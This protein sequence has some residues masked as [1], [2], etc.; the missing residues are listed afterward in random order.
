M[1]LVFYVNTADEKILNKKNYLSQAFT[2][3]NIVWKEDTSILEPTFTFHKFRQEGIQTWKDFNYVKLNWGASDD[4][5]NNVMRDRYYFV[6]DIILKEGGILEVQCYED[7]RYTWWKYIK[8]QYLLIARN[9]FIYNKIMPDS[10][11]P[12]PLT[13]VTKTKSIGVVGDGGDG[14]ILLTVSGGPT[15]WTTHTT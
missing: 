10:R 14:T 1:K 11:K 8:T 12:L 9:E 3:D 6:K 15:H 5:P 2:V 4:D 13:K 7:L